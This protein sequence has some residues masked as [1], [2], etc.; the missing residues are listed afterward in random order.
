[1]VPWACLPTFLTARHGA[2]DVAQ[3]VEGV[4]DRKTSMPFSAALST[5]RSTTMSS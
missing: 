5:K 1:M 2:L 4:E 3:V